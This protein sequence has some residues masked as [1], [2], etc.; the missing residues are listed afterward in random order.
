MKTSGAD[1][2]HVLVPIT[3]RYSYKDTYEFAERVSRGLEAENP[4]LVT[5]EWLKKK[6]RGVLVDHR[7]NGHGKTIASAYSV[8]PKPGAPVSTPLRW[9]ELGEKVRPRDFGMRE[10][11]AGREA[12][13][14]V[15]ARAAGRSG[16][17]PGASL[18]ARGVKSAVVIGSGPNGLAARD[19]DGPRRPEV[20]VHEAAATVGGGMRSEELTLPGFTHD[21]CSAIHPLGRDSPF[22]RDLELPVGWVQPDAPAAHPLDDGTA[23]TTERSLLATAEGLGEDRGA[24]LRVVDRIVSR[25]SDYEPVV[26]GPFL[27]RRTA[28][29]VG[30]PTSPFA[31]APVSSAHGLAK[32]FRRAR[33]SAPGRPRGAL[34]APAGEEAER[35]LRPAPDARPCLRLGLPAGGSQASRMRSPTGSRSSAARLT[36]EPCR[37]AAS[38][39]RR[40]RR[41]RAARLLRIA[42]DRLPARYAAL[43]ATGTAREPSSSTGHST[44]RSRGARAEC[45]A[46]RDRAP[47]RHVRRDRRVGARPRGRAGRGTPVRP[48]GAA[49][50]LRP[51]RAPRPAAHR[52]GLLPRAV[53]LDAG[54]DRPRSRRRSSASRPAS[55][56]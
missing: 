27:P 15:R 4:G 32:R 17:R 40:P 24:Y 1:G 14:P 16:T 21:V 38:R 47:R 52:L 29:H 56:P 45:S 3:R 54:H 41:R 33:P 31:P 19:H 25:W 22:F 46:R 20:T 23:V 39:R 51:T 10:A 37:R 7:Q 43:A 42:G 11:L 35:W 30:P 53:R 8:R 6:R 13:R 18:F 36:R 12:R 26:L 28:L 50:P 34:H 48:A 55:A 2:I 5:T 49:V 9:E 44:A